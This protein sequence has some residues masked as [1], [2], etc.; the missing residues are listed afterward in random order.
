MDI[1]EDITNMN[2]MVHTME[3]QEKATKS[4]I[5]HIVIIAQTLARQKGARITPITRIILMIKTRTKNNLV[6]GD[7][8]C[9]FHL[10]LVIPMYIPPK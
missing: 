4:I 5:T 2:T 10:Y 3:V 6:S 9:Q 8:I 7:Q 1:M